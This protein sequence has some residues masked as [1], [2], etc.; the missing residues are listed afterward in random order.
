MGRMTKTYEGIPNSKK[1][2]EQ[3][4]GRRGVINKNKFSLPGVVLDSVNFIYLCGSIKKCGC[5]N[6]WEDDRG[7]SRCHDV[8]KRKKEE[9]FIQLKR[10]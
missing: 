6:E 7:M 2:R 5:F 10:V 4:N 8:L 1:L 3:R 9:K